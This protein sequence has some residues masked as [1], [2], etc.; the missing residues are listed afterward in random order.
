MF[1]ALQRRPGLRA[2]CW[3]GLGAAARLLSNLPINMTPGHWARLCLLTSSQLGH[4]HHYPDVISALLGHLI[5][6]CAGE[7]RGSVLLLV[8]TFFKPSYIVDENNILRSKLYSQLL[9]SRQEQCSVVTSF[10]F[11]FIIGQVWRWFLAEDGSWTVGW[12]PFFEDFPMKKP[13]CIAVWINHEKQP[14]THKYWVWQHKK[15][16]SMCLFVMRVWQRNQWSSKVL[17]LPK[18]EH[19]S[20][21]N[22]QCMGSTLTV[23]SISCEQRLDIVFQCTELL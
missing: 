18:L 15:T 19:K 3:A 17:L 23:T 16:A 11:I 6:H 7:L 2:D 10:I 20:L 9:V 14:K 5:V 1:E 13:H 22:K 4:H 12:F 8:D 21:E